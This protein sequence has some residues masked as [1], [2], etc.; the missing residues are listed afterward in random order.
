[1]IVSELIDILEAMNP[2][3][4]IVMSGDSEGN[5]YN[6]LREIDDVVFDKRE[7]EIGY[8][9]LTEDLIKQGYTDEDLIE[10]GVPAVCLWP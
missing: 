1:M 8:S 5:Y 4:I 3:S 9:E 2:D 10:D 6:E 7:Q